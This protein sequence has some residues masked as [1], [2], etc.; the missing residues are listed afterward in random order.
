M[1]IINLLIFISGFQIPQAQS[2]ELQRLFTTPD[3]RNALNE[4]R[5]RPPPP[6]PTAQE[7]ETFDLPD[8]PRFITFNGLMQQLE[9]TTVWVNG[10]TKLTDK[11]FMV[12]INPDKTVSI[13]LPKAKFVVRLRAGQT[14]DTVNN[15]ILEAYQ[16]FPDV[17]TVTHSPLNRWLKNWRGL[18]LTK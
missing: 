18:K 17:N 9:Y 7:L 16:K 8:P 1:L 11:S 5:F 2:E 10:S 12:Q 4:N 13:V 15:E 3:E 14:L 6:P